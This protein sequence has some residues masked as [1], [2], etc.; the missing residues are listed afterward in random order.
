MPP[1]QEKVE[2][3]FNREFTTRSTYT[4]NQ[5]PDYTVA[6]H[7]QGYDKPFW[8]LFDAKYR[9]NEKQGESQLSF[10]APD[11][12]I[13]QLHRYRDA[14]LHSEIKSSTYRQAIKNLGGIILYP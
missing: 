7:K 6:F 11:D 4:F 8:Y 10:E 5:R 3:F 14:I 2:V 13:G 12:A 1:N 9:F